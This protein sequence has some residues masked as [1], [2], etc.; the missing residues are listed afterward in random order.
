MLNITR[1]LLYKSNPYE[2]PRNR[3]ILLC[4]PLRGNIPLAENICYKRMKIEKINFKSM[5]I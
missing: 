5:K 4:I 1:Q 3:K 2:I